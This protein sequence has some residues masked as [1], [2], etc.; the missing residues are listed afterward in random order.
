MKRRLRTGDHLRGTKFL[1]PH[2]SPRN[3]LKAYVWCRRRSRRRIYLLT[4]A[5]HQVLESDRLA[6]QV[7]K[8]SA[9]QRISD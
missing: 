9:H 2:P 5:G 8:V 6:T 7:C 4:N 3:M 1:Q